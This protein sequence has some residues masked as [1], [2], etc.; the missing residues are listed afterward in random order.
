ME[1]AFWVLIGLGALLSPIIALASLWR[2]TKTLEREVWR[3]RRRVTVLEKGDLV[4][5]S[6]L[7]P[8]EYSKTSSDKTSIS[9]SAPQVVP[10]VAPLTLEATEAVA[11]EIGNS[12]T[13]ETLSSDPSLLGEP[14]FTSTSAETPAQ[15]QA[16]SR[17]RP[18][19]A[20]ASSARTNAE[21]EALI[22]GRLFNRIGAA[23]IVIGMGFFLKYAFDNELI[24]EPLRVL[25]GVILGAG[26]I[27]VAER[28]KAKDLRVFAQGLL[29]AG[30][31][32]LYLSVYAAYNFYALAPV[33]QAFAGMIAVTVVGFT[34][35]LRFNSFAVALLAWFGGYLT[36][37]LIHSPQPNPLG[38]FAY[39]AILSAG[40]LALVFRRDDWFKLKPLSFCAAYLISFF[41]YINAYTTL[42]HFGLTLFFAVLLWAMFFAADFYR[43][44]SGRSLADKTWKRLDSL[45]NS[46]VSYAALFALV[47]DVYPDWM[48]LCSF[49]YGGAYFL[50]SRILLRKRPDHT[51]GFMRYT[52]TAITQLT[53]VIAQAL[54]G[55]WAIIGWSAEFAFLAWAGL[56]W[57]RPFVSVAGMIISAITLPYLLFWQGFSG[58]ITTMSI[59]LH[60]ADSFSLAETLWLP[61]TMYLAGGA[62]LLWTALL[63]PR[64]VE[65]LPRLSALRS[66]N[67]Y[68]IAWV[69]TAVAGLSFALGYLF[70]FE[71]SFGLVRGEYRQFYIAVT[72]MATLALVLAWVARRRA[73]REIAWLGWGIGALAAVAAVWRGFVYEPS[74]EWVFA[75]NIRAVGIASIL[76][77]ALALLR[78]YAPPG[79]AL[80]QRF[81][82]F[83][84]NFWGACA[85]AL[86]FALLSGE[87]SDAFHSQIMRLY[88]LP[89]YLQANDSIMQKIADLENAKQLALSLAWLLYASALMAF[90]FARRLRAARLAALGLAAAAILK[91]FLYD[92]SYLRT[93]YR[94]GSFIG[95]GV[96]LMLT[97]YLYQRFKDRI[98]EEAVE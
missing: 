97:S 89:A 38:L 4:L 39:L 40:M 64:I 54:D 14:T 15:P 73:W 22:G 23:A 71:R 6:S 8:T 7:A 11:S 96:I 29:G 86:V 42:E 62:A 94:I 55:E 61:M 83:V 51:F 56:R 85:F 31:G 19:S 41:W 21:W 36:P 91:I 53:F 79:A 1:E 92:L 43:A 49:L 5:V 12:T 80:N 3:L 37:L 33:G 45:L 46:G 35:A 32:V 60:S 18:K 13:M 82:P 78:L 76:L 98:F 10:Q 81:Q 17:V 28:W 72:T 27:A 95:L 87:T 30:I 66:F 50:A 67:I 65:G 20:P 52:L 16:P 93:P 58:L 90:G 84:R 25:L 24:S 70:S 88:D 48:P 68:H 34:F 59:L 44:L 74:A 47:D 9:H 69:L 75:L 77:I 63:F 57:N 26:L 2:K